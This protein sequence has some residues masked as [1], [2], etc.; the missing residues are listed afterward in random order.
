MDIRIFHKKDGGVVQLIELDKIQEWD[1]EM[2]FKFVDYILNNKLRSYRDPKVEGEISKYCD[3]I[4]KK[5]GLPKVKELFEGGDR[6]AIQSTLDIFEELS[7]IN[8]T[9]V[10][11]IKP[12]L[13]DLIKNSIKTIGNQA[14]KILKNMQN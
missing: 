8:A 4:L 12:L 11:P 7:E 9:A 1:V 14:Q 13:E 3:E 5:V 6:E 2:P 10:V